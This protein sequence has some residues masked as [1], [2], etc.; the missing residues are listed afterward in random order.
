VPRWTAAA[1]SALSTGMP[2]VRARA[3]ALGSAPAARATTI[4]PPT[5]A[6]AVKEERSTPAR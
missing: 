6:R 1:A 4:A 2:A 5:G 3:A